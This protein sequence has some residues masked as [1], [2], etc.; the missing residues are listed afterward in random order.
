MI[1]RKILLLSAL[2][3]SILF[4][5]G[6]KK[7]EDEVSV[8]E[9]FMTTTTEISTTATQIQ[10]TT[11]TVATTTVTAETTDETADIEIPEKAVYKKTTYRVKDGERQMK[12]VSFF[13]RHDNVIYSRY[14]NLS[15]NIFSDIHYVYKYNDNGTISSKKCIA[16]DYGMTNCHEYEYNEN[17]TLKSIL[18]FT[19]ELVITEVYEC[20]EN[21]DILSKNTFRSNESELYSTEIH[22]Y[23]YDEN[24][25]I[26]KDIITKSE[27]SGD[28]EETQMLDYTYDENGNILIKHSVI[29]GVQHTLAMDINDD[30]MI[31]Y[32]YNSDNQCISAE[33][34]DKDGNI[35]IIEYEYYEN[36]NGYIGGVKIPENAVYEQTVTSYGEYEFYD[37]N[38]NIFDKDDNI[39]INVEYRSENGE[40]NRKVLYTYD[41][42]GN[43]IKEDF[44][45]DNRLSDYIE[46][47][48]N[49]NGI[50]ISDTE[51]DILNNDEVHEIKTDYIY[52]DKGRL[53]AEQAYQND[54]ESWRI[55]YEYDEQ[56]RLVKENFYSRINSY[57]SYTYDEN[58]NLAERTS[59]GE[60]GVTV[61]YYTYDENN[62]LVKSEDYHD[63]EWLY[64]YEYEYEFY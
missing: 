19:D 63:G 50:M 47:E 48:Y 32:T 51:Y 44:Y 36:C 4:S 23:E 12:E 54:H 45:V 10:T 42:D 16:E 39:L 22:E 28:Y 30:N 29:K 62:R 59:D 57:F 52:D 1:D 37:R 11:E 38:V 7:A 60:F 3:V 35:S 33:I 61:T 25:R 24:G 34:T 41:A 64:T 9:T 17:G 6:D 58:G 55:E 31:I 14:F 8:S 5:C 43:I 21:G 49:E 53:S 46:Y 40:P 27:D 18:Y 15:S 13:D 20:N 2:C 26:T 56:D